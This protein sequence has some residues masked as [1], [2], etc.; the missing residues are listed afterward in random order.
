MPVSSGTNFVAKNKES[1]V[2]VMRVYGYSRVSTKD[3]NLD[4]Q[5]IDLKNY[6]DERFIFM[7]KQSGKDFDRPQYQLMKKVAQKGDVI[8][9]KSLDRLGR[10]K[11]QVKSELEYY[12]KYSFSIL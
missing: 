2:F 7:D 4:R 10:N 1:E 9:I 12:K 3:Q 6:V 8:Y 5:L 11:A